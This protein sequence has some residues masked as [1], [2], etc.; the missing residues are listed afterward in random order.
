MWYFAAS[1][2]TRGGTQI[3]VSAQR[4]IGLCWLIASKSAESKDERGSL[5]PAKSLWMLCGGRSMSE[6]Y[7]GQGMYA[8]SGK[9]ASSGPGHDVEV[10][11]ADVVEPV[12]E[13][14]S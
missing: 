8:F 11:G 4:C 7:A 6:G 10:M 5:R 9:S 12:Y 3:Y 2:E 14:G 1:A 13:K